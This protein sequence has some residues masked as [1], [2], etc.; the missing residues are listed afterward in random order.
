MRVIDEYLRA[1][2]HADA[3][4]PAFGAGE[5]FE[6]GEHGAGI[7]AGRDGKPGRYQCV[8][9]LKFADQ[10]QMNLKSASLVFELKPLRKS[11]DGG[12]KE[13]DAGAV[14]ADAHDRRPRD[15]AAA[16]DFVRLFVI[17]VDDRRCARC[18]QIGEQPQFASR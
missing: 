2:A 15:F 14:A 1:A 18:Q 8:L 13:T 12:M 7:A 10:R 5:V 3:L 4:Q 6:R 16:V 9:D 11:V 17:D